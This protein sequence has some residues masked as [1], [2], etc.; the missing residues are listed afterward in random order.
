V[1]SSL[2]PRVGV[3][4]VD[5]SALVKLAVHE[6]ESSVVE[7][8]LA[9]W[10]RIAT[11]ELTSIEL[12]RAVARARADGRADVADSRVVME[13]LA[14]VAVVP[15]TEDV[16]ALAAQMEP[17]TLRTLDAVHLASALALG[18]DVAGVLTYDRRMADAAAQHDLVLLA[19][20]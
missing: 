11:S 9:A 16:R 15:L 14:A 13:I 4:Y 20:T 8:E 5:T 1:A 2:D 3:L 17:S 18:D 12:P 10:D 7:S 6:A 19:P